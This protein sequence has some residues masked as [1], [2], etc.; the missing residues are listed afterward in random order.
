MFILAYF[1]SVSPYYPISFHVLF[2][3]DYVILYKTPHNAYHILHTNVHFGDNHFL[4]TSNH[5]FHN[6][7]PDWFYFLLYMGK[8]VEL[9]IRNQANN[10]VGFFPL[11]SYKARNKLWKTCYKE[12]AGSACINGFK[13]NVLR[14]TSIKFILY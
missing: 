4:R 5:P 12:S 1:K 11:F 13:A 8:I 2:H 3:D 14:S 6:C 7:S 9:K 10:L